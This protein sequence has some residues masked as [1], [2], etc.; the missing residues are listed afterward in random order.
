MIDPVW[1]EGCSARY[2]IEGSDEFIKTYPQFIK[3]VRRIYKGKP[4]LLAKTGGF[5]DGTITLTF[6]NPVL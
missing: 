3:E 6:G 1:C 4:V 2:Y 5:W